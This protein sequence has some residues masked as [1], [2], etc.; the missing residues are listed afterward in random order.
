MKRII[1]GLVL[2]SLFSVAQASPFPGNGDPVFLE[3]EWTHAERSAG[4][5]DGMKLGSAIPGNGDPVELPALSTYADAHVN[6]PNM[7]AGSAIPGNGDPV[8]LPAL[9]T[10]ADSFAPKSVQHASASIE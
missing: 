6:E 8:E 5:D 9:S 10:Y 7:Q 4:Q 3:P 1:Q 2:A